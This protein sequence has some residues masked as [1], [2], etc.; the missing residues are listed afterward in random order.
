MMDVI[1]HQAVGP[2]LRTRPA[3]RVREQVAVERVVTVLEKR[4]LAAVA[5]LGH[6]IRIAGQHE[7]RK[8]SHAATIVVCVAGGGQ[9]APVWCF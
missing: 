5:A 8:T 1:G 2:D 4:L 9:P 3:S 7:A 6:V